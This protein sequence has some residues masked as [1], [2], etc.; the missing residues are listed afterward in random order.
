ML[1]NVMTKYG[2]VEGVPSPTEGIAIFKGVP[3]AKPP[4]G[5]LR[6]R[7]P[8][9]PEKWEGV[10]KCD[11]YMN[12]AMQS[13][14]KVPFYI[15]EFPIDYTKVTFGE[16]CLYLN[17]WTPAKS[18]DEKLP[19]MMWIHG[20]GNEV[21]FPH[22][23]E[24]DGDGLASRGVI[25]V[26]V[27]Y[28]LNI[29]GFFAHPELTAESE[30]G[31]SGNYGN[32]DHLA[33][34]RWLRE[35]IAAFGGDPDNITIFGQSAGAGDVHTLAVNPLAK[36]LFNRAISMSGSGAASLMRTARLSDLE[37]LGLEFQK[38]AGCSSLA[39]L[40]AAPADFLFK[41]SEEK[42]F[43]FGTCVDNY[44]LSD[45]FSNL[46]REGKH[47]KVS[48]MVGSCSH[49]GAAFGEGYK[50]SVGTFNAQV[51]R[52]F[53]D[54]A[55][56]AIELYGVKTDE[57]AKNCKRDLM[58]DGA[59]YG[60]HLWALAHLEHGLDPV[61][62]YLFDRCIPDRDGNP[63]WESS[64]HSGDLWY[65][66]GTLGR[67]WRGM[68]PDDYKTSN[69]MMD[70]W[71][72]FAKTGDPNGEGLPVWKPY[73][74]EEPGTMVINENAGMSDLLDNPGVKILA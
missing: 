54:Y 29:F 55:E 66:H 64:Y 26:S 18:A 51:E 2:A 49:E 44:I 7:A 33:A 11:K 9:P 13:K 48:Y 61:Y 28:R 36:G 71:T 53:R 12:G 57:D 10:R 3:F 62:L 30:Y 22:E 23:P 6:W 32:L 17:I 16:D 14:P 67:S 5:E 58:A 15:D 21:G 31:A 19:V 69:L 40:R 43:N 41:L 35:N 1:L 39:E 60:T 59:A 50:N 47:H 74:R 25:Y 63:S 8:Q 72:N 4:V 37:A 56:K 20:G 68:G 42:H 34:L 24:H 70:Y 27:T 52:M 45:D 38:A 65:V 46:I 73:T